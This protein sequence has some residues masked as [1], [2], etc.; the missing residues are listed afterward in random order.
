MEIILPLFKDFSLQ[1]GNISESQENY[2]TGP[3][4]KGL[5]LYD[6]G[7]ELAEEGVGIGVP[8]IK[9]GL[10]TIFPG[11]I[12]L[13]SQHKDNLWV[14]T[15]LYKM[16]LEER[17][18]R[19]GQRS[20]SIGLVYKIKNF[21]AAIYRQYPASRQLLT[22]IS[23]LIQWIFHWETQYTKSKYNLDIK[24][25]YSIQSQTGFVMVEVDTGNLPK[26]LIT[27]V[28]LMNEQGANYFDCYQDSNGKFIKGKD[29]GAWDEV[30]AKTAA[31]LCLAH[32][33]SFSLE[34]VKGAKLF[35]GRELV[36]SRLAWSGFGYS[37]PMTA[38]KFNY[39][40]KIES[41]P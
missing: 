11:N 30:T 27:E 14:I 22:I 6:K 36:G 13:I 15:A 9:Q 39:Q 24:I 16:N 33:V 25:V 8:V 4:Q 40:V 17:V 37:I 34:Q 31:F 10:H 19:Q 28:V 12:E 32:K 1:I 5:R 18:G 26:D 3:L 35:S 2:P 38:N 23:N 20:V 7:L 29:I 41:L 21:L